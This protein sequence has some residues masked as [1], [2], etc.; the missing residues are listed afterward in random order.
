VLSFLTHCLYMFTYMYLFSSHAY[1]MYVCSV[2][3]FL[4]TRSLCMC[5]GVLSFLIWLRHRNDGIVRLLIKKQK[6][7][8]RQNSSPVYFLW[9][10]WSRIPIVLLLILKFK[11][12]NIAELNIKIT[13][14]N[15]FNGYNLYKLLLQQN[16]CFS[17]IICE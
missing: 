1:F 9:S 8:K 2:L 15:N 6:W 11:R 5:V 3:S 4:L 13:K 10:F 16:I 12:K 14:L 17:C 7:R